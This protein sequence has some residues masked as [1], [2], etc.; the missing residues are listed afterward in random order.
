[1]ASADPVAKPL[2]LHWNSGKVLVTPQDNDRFVVEAKMAIASCQGVVAFDRF[3]QQ[4]QE[5]FLTRLYKWCEQYQSQVRACYV[6]FP[7]GA[8]IPVFVI[9][10]SERFDFNLNDHISDLEL[11]L[12]QVGWRADIVQLPLAS[13]ETFSSFFK[14][15]GS[16]QVYGDGEG[17]RSESQSQSGVSQDDN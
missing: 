13:P 15:S 6:P 2:Q 9:G 1:M 17:T 14:L 16:I 7:T 11:E 5:D 10:S 12:D 4:F 3:W 8:D